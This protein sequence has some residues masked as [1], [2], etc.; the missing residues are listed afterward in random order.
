MER[1]KKLQKHAR[2]KMEV[3]RLLSKYTRLKTSNDFPLLTGH[4]KF[5]KE[6]TQMAKAIQMETR[7]DGLLNLILEVNRMIQGN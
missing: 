4:H 6:L 5:R 1:N 7:K 3:K 2:Y